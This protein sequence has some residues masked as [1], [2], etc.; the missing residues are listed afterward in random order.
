MWILWII[1][2][3]AVVIVIGTIVNNKGGVIPDDKIGLTNSKTNKQ[4]KQTSKDKKPPKF[5]NEM[6]VYQMVSKIENIRDL[7]TLENKAESLALKF[8]NTNNEEYDILSKKYTEA[9]ELGASKTFKFQFIPNYETDTPLEILKQ[10]YRIVDSKDLLFNNIQNIDKYGS[11]DEYKGNDLLHDTLKDIVEPKPDYW[12]SA[13]K[14]RQIKE[15]DKPIN[16]KKE[17]FLKLI[18]SDESFRDNF[19]SDSAEELEEDLKKYLRF[20]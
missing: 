2:G 17:A 10:S 1:L 12:E 4:S 16:E 13:I 8:F 14:F 11:W 18:H 6:S 9:Y 20:S 15:S 5:N 3:I 19:F 7:K